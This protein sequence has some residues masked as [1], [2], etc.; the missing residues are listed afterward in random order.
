MLATRNHTTTVVVA[1]WCLAAFAPAAQPTDLGNAR[2]KTDNFIFYAQETVSDATLEDTAARAEALI[3]T[4]QSFVGYQGVSTPFRYNVFAT[5]EEKGLATGYTLPA[6]ALYGSGEIFAAVEAGFEGEADRVLAGLVVRRA[7]GKTKVELLET[8][9]AMYF[10]HNWGGEGYLHWA[11]RI[12]RMQGTADLE[13]LL[14]NDRIRTESRLIV[15]PLAGAFASYVIERFGRAVL[16]EKYAA[17]EPTA[18]E[19]ASLEPEWREYLSKLY[20]SYHDSITKTRSKD[21]PLTPFQKGFCQ[22]HE[23]YQIHN[24]YASLRSDKA[25]EKLASIGV[26]AVSITPFTY[27]RDPRAAAPLPFIRQA[28]AENDESVIHATL[29]SQQLGMV[30]MLKPHLWIHGGWPGDIEMSSEDEWD[31]FFDFYWSWIRH[32]ALLA[33]MYDIGLLCVGVELSATTV[34]HE[35]RWREVLEKVRVI[36]SGKITYAAN[37]GEE[38]EKVRF[39]D[40]LDFIGVNFYYPLS[41]ENYP[42]DDRLREGVEMAL[43]KVD[44]VSRRHGKRVIITEVGFTSS[45]TPWI[46]PY[47]RDRRARADERAQARCY[48]AFIAG[49]RDRSEYAGVYWWKWPSFLEYGGPEHSGYTPN[50]KIAEKIV[51]RWYNGK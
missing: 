51:E 5:I 20:Q 1:L 8:G 19:I 25:L 45:P 35:A 31:R 11:A 46:E 40:S 16:V 30:V 42:S 34:G 38:F 48:E 36:Y 13:T 7:L 32:Y 2:L 17:W 41:D 39:W 24:G 27:M 12:G 50:G 15:K 28:G 44:A 37:W 23:G 22:A 29:V 26:N 47:R 43:A 10:T 9:F 21:R 18:A 4:V 3:N 33:E 49:L 14:D 6:H